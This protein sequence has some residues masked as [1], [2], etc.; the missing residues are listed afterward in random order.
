VVRWGP[1]LRSRAEE[2]VSVHQLLPH[3]LTLGQHPLEASFASTDG[4]L[5]SD[6]AA[7]TTTIYAN[8]PD[9][10]LSLSQQSLNIGYGSTSSPISLQVQSAS[11]MSGTVTYACTGLPVGMTCTF[12]PSTSAITD[13]ATVTTSF[14]ITSKSPSASSFTGLKGWSLALATIPILLVARARR[15]NV[16]LVG[17]Y[18]QQRCSSSSSEACSAVRVVP[19]RA[20]FKRPEVKRFSSVRHAERS[21]RPSH[22]SSTFNKEGSRR[23]SQLQKGGKVIQLGCPSLNA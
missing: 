23:K 8:S 13:G 17:V 7:Q 20:L 12:G 22:S 4:S 5:P 10:Q 2:R 19:R 16:K 1:V 15:R 18:F 14:T 6:S 21:R 9:L 11:G 3:T